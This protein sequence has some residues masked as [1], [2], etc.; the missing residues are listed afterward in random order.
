MLSTSGDM[1][2]FTECFS[3]LKV[4][5][6][7]S[8]YNFGIEGSLSGNL[9]IFTSGTSSDYATIASGMNLFVETEATSENNLLTLFVRGF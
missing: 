3:S 9:N 2:L 4:Y 8:L 7:M 6:N 5:N 1:N